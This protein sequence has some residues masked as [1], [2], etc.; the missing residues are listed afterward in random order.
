[1]SGHHPFQRLVENLPE[2][3]KLEIERKKKELLTAIELRA[4]ITWVN[5]GIHPDEFA[6][7][8]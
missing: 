2:E 4:A 6:V 5:H 8:T 1:M 7:Q 3:R